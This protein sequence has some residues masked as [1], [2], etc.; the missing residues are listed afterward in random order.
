M[1][2]LKPEQ[3]KFVQ[4]LMSGLSQRQAFLA[5]FP[6]SKN[7]KVESVDSKASSLFKSDKVQERYR[8]LLY[9]TAEAGKVTRSS[10]VNKVKRIAFAPV[11]Y[12]KVRPAD[13]IRALELLA[14]L[15]GLDTGPDDD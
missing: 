12:E 15:T 3:E 6:N 2:N 11:D 7:W 8:E 5:A 10:L 4:G 14:K 9:E 1:S 13:Q